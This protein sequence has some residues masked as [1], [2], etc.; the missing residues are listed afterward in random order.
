[1]PFSIDKCFIDIKQ[2]LIYCKVIRLFQQFCQKLKGDFR[3]ITSLYLI[4]LKLYYILST[5]MTCLLFQNYGN[6]VLMLSSG[7]ALSIILV[8]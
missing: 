6:N 1:M 2:L 8:L 4:P 3:M 5:S 7:M